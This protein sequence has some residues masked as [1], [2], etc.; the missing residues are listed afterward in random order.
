MAN[1]FD[2][3]LEKRLS[4]SFIKAFESQRVLSRTVNTQIAETNP[5][6]SPITGDTIYVRR[7][8]RT[9]AVETAKGDI[10]GLTRDIVSGQAP[11]TVQNV[12]T[13]FAEWDVVDEALKMD[14]LDEILRPYAVELVTKLEGNLGRFMQQRSGLL[15]GTPGTAIT[16]WSDVAAFNTLME[17]IGVPRD[18]NTYAVLSPAVRENLANVQSGLANGDNTLVNEAWRNALISKDFGGL[19]ALSS[20][21]VPVY[22]SGASSTRTGTVQ[23]APTATYVAHK[24]TMI[25]TVTLTGLSASVANAIRPGDQIRVT[26]ANRSRINLNTKDI[27]FD[28]AGAQIAW[29]WTVVTGGTTDAG[30]QVTITVTAPAINE[31]NGAYNNISSAIQAG[32][33]FA[34]LGTANTSYQSALFYHRDA[35]AL[36]SIRM[37]KLHAKDTIMESKDGFSI[38]MTRYS[39]GD[40]NTNKIRFD[41]WPAFGVLEPLFA[42][43]GFGK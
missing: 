22:Q 42:G 28:Q 9:T 39:N 7:P 15:S 5:G 6:F 3:N 43:N 25:Q 27:V 19:R 11:V 38:R 30:G 31:A 24:D 40:A 35:F 16:K 21:H 8:Y 14:R 32:D 10:T 13:T 4:K 20:N 18:G 36:A 41:L 2:S 26:Q 34:L 23:A 37:P 17:S 12:I 29:T 1:N 33:T